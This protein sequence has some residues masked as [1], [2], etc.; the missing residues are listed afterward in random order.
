MYFARFLCNINLNSWTHLLTPYPRDVVFARSR[1]VH[2]AYTLSLSQLAEFLAT[3]R[4]SPRYTGL[5]WTE[6]EDVWKRFNGND[7]V[8]YDELE[9]YQE[10]QDIEG[11]LDFTIAQVD[12][13]DDIF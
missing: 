4:V 13:D 10:L 9:T 11:Y 2:P 7:L 5:V 8:F 3:S 12:Q 6:L 1:A